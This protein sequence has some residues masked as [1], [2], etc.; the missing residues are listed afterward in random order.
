MFQT[1]K[2][3]ATQAKAIESAQAIAQL[4]LENAEAIA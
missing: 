1:D 2:L 3:A 4:A